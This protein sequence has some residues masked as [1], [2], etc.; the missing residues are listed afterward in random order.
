MIDGEDYHRRPEDCEVA[1]DDLKEE[2]GCIRALV[3]DVGAG[4]DF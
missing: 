3:G 1:E 4:E 2:L